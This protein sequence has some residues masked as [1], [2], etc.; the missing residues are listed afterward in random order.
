MSTAINSTHQQ[1]R[2][3]QQKLVN[4]RQH[5]S[6]QGQQ[7]G[8]AFSQ[9]LSLA[10]DEDTD[11][12]ALRLDGKLFG[13][14]ADD[15]GEA[16]D[17]GTPSKR[18][19]GQGV[20]AG[21]ADDAD[22]VPD[23][24]HPAAQANAVLLALLAQAQDAQAH[25]PNVQTGAS[26]PPTAETT[27]TLSVNSQNAAVAADTIAETPI[28]TTL[29]ADTV[30]VPAAAMATS[31][32]TTT[33]SSAAAAA[34]AAAITTTTTEPATADTAEK[35][36]P[37]KAVR[38]L[39]RQLGAAMNNARGAQENTAQTQD[40]GVAWGRQP[41]AESATVTAQV[42]SG[43][44][45]TSGSFSASGGHEAQAWA[46]HARPTSV[47]DEPGATSDEPEAVPEGL[48]PA[49]IRTSGS[50][51]QTPTGLGGES[52]GGTELAERT[53]TAEEAGNTAEQWRDQWA[54]AMDQMAQQVSYW[55]GQGGVR[56]A[57][58][59]VG[60]GWQQTMDVKLSLKDGQ[61]HI[62]FQTDHEAAR[63]AIADGGAE[64][65]RDLLA[66]S[67]IDL[68]QVSIG[69]QNSGGG[70]DPQARGQAGH[71]GQR[72]APAGDRQAPP[73]TTLRPRN[74][75]STGLDVYV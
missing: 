28:A 44:E 52:L 6:A 24:L 14:K 27:T 47:G 18:K 56:Q 12:D 68:G 57:T 36:V 60:N 51:G 22:G 4:A 30:Q 72:T 23:G 53:P 65:L 63:S 5:A 74:T 42:A 40:N 37:G 10:C 58:L 49:E 66:Q 43:Q 31:P 19:P 67:G 29:V 46:A 11:L 17:A 26:A 71:A 41:A 59:R 50:E 70:A 25:V 73:A 2:A 3:A 62:E 69:A 61:A 35:T 64:V 48:A 1:D 13:L 9:M 75:N 7:Q 21:L 16:A 32:A 55:V 34:A 39:A 20:G 45:A 8:V 38:D 33:S 54:D 15:K